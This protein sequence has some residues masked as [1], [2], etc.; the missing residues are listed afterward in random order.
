MDEAKN[1][2]HPAVEKD[3]LTPEA[4]AEIELEF[5]LNTPVRTPIRWKF[6]TVEVEGEDENAV[7]VSIQNP[8]G[9]WRFV[10]SHEE[11]LLF[12]R[13]IRKA[14]MGGTDLHLP[15]GSI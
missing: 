10:F 8:I 7:V 11:A 13:E 6:T 3:P 12:G 9:A 1:G 4:A 14:V 5:E 2:D 15:K